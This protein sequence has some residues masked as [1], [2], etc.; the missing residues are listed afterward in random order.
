MVLGGVAKGNDKG[1]GRRGVDVF[2]RV[3]WCGGNF[4]SGICVKNYNWWDVSVAVVLVR[5]REVVTES[6]QIGGGR[7]VGVT[8]SLRRATV[9]REVVVV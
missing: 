5:M 4:F 9:E 7:D 1:E 6:S 3:L 2:P 8:G